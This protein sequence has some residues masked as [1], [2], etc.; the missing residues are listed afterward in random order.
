[1]CTI[2]ATHGVSS[3]EWQ[4][5]HAALRTYTGELVVH[6]GE[7][8][9]PDEDTVPDEKAP[10]DWEELS[11]EEQ[12]EQVDRYLEALRYL[13]EHPYEPPPEDQ[14][15]AEIQRL[16][17]EIPVD[18]TDY[19]KAF[20]DRLAREWLEVARHQPVRWTG[21]QTVLVVYRRLPQLGALSRMRALP[22]QRR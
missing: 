21:S 22:P 2:C 12:N 5:F 15:E 19:T 3:L 11:E 17:A 16:A 7:F 20:F 6:L 8:P 9:H 1:L 4:D 18:Q 13:D 10:K 14:L